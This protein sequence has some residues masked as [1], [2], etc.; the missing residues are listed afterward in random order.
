MLPSATSLKMTQFQNFEITGRPVCLMYFKLFY[1]LKVCFAYLWYT[2]AILQ[3]GQ[4]G[5]FC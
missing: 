3:A 5:R 1:E 4:D 2:A